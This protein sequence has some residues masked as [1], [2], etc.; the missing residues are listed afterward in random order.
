MD[1]LDFG[2]FLDKLEKKNS[3][4]AEYRF[5]EYIHEN[6]LWNF[7]L[8]NCDF[9]SV[10]QIFKD[11]FHQFWIERGMS[12]RAQINNDELLRNLLR[13]LLSPYQDEK[14]TLYRGEDI[15]DYR[16]NRIGFCW[17]NDLRIAKR[18]ATRNAYNGIKLILSG[19]FDKDSIIT[20]IHFEDDYMDES[21]YIVD[22]FKITNI[23]IIEI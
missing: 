9:D 22:P 6:K 10:T 15:N 14:I 3:K 8:S 4:T 7:L 23:T 12:I 20:K 17:T 2:D 13:K 19:I 21:E 5:I 11:E 18:F 16:E 1:D